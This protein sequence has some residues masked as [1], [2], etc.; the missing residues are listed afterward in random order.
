[1]VFLIIRT[2]GVKNSTRDPVRTQQLKLFVRKKMLTLK[3]IGGL[4]ILPLT[5][6]MLFLN[7]I[8]IIVLH[9]LHFF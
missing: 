4:K 3:K 2:R 9:L 1:M 7:K 6:V 5:E 8:H